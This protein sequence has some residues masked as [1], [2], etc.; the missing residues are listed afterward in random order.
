MPKLNTPHIDAATLQK[1]E[2]VIAGMAEEFRLLLK[3]YLSQIEESLSRLKAEGTPSSDQLRAMFVLVN[4][5][6]GEAGSMGYELMTMVA[7]RL[8]RYLKPATD[9][10]VANLEV[11][12]IHVDAIRMIIQQDLRGDGGRE[13]QILCTGLDEIVAKWALRMAQGN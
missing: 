8:C 9:N 5:L 4:N 7:Y 11:V 12:S 6:K 13:G 1:A 3:T 10:Q 2:A